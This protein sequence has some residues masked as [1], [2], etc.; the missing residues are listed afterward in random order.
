MGS[1]ALSWQSAC[2]AKSYHLYSDMGSGFGIYVLRA[3]VEKNSFI[4]ANLRPDTLYRYRVIARDRDREVSLV[5]LAVTTSPSP[6][7]ASLGGRALMPLPTPTRVAVTVTPAPTPLPPDTVVLGVLSA[8]DHV[9]EID[10]H[11]IIVGEVR[12]DSNMNVGD[13]KVNVVLYDAQ[14]VRQGEVEGKPVLSTL[15][16]GE[17]APFVLKLGSLGSEIHYSVR[18]TARAQ[19]TPR[20]RM[21]A[22]LHVLSTRRFEDDV[23]LYHIAGVVANKGARRVERA[24]VV[25]VLYDRG[26]RVINV[27]FGYPKPT[28]LAPGEHADFDV[29]FTYYPKVVRHTVLLVAD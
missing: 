7:G 24:R 27:G 2:R 29:T 12:N 28:V 19:N 25:V 10:G 11:L 1:V 4:D 16:P 26:D 23:G 6:V 3:E 18:A 15:A 13:A 9:D 21:P 20:L 8:S 14:G 5:D 17:S 22:A